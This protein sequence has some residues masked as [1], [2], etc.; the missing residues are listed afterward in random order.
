M[1]RELELVKGLVRWQLDQGKEVCP[2]EDGKRQGVHDIVKIYG[3]FF[4]ANANR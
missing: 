2:L 1:K 3:R 4:Y